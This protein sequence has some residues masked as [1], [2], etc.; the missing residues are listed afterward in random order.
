MKMVDLDL[1]LDQLNTVP[2]GQGLTPDVK[3]YN[4]DSI[5]LVGYFNRLFVLSISEI[6][7]LN[8]SH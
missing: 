2:G 7:S 6:R 1:D 5:Y 4:V 8:I 3:E